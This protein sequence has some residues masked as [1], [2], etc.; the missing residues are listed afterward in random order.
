MMEGHTAKLTVDDSARTE[1]VVA[2]YERH[3]DFERLLA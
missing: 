2:H 3:I 1:A